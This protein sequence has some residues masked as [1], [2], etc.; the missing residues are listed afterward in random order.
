MTSGLTRRARE[1]LRQCRKV[2]VRLRRLTPEEITEWTRP[3]PKPPRPLL[4]P[5]IQKSIANLPPDCTI[6]LAPVD[7]LQSWM[8]PNPKVQPSLVVSRPEVKISVVGRV[9]QPGVGRLAPRSPPGL[10]PLITNAWSMQTLQSVRPKMNNQLLLPDLIPVQR[11]PNSRPSQP[12]VI[13]MPSTSSPKPAA[14]YS[15]PAAVSRGVVIDLCSSDEDDPP[16]KPKEFKSPGLD[17]PLFL[18]P[19][20]SITQIKREPIE[21]RC[22]VPP[23]PVQVKAEQR[24]GTKNNA[25]CVSTACTIR[26]SPPA[27]KF[28]GQQRRASHQPEMIRNKTG[29]PALSMDSSLPVV[30]PIKLGTL[31]PE[32]REQMKQ[33]LLKIQQK[34]GMTS[35]SNTG[36]KTSSPP[37]ATGT[38]KPSRNSV[39][40]RTSPLSSIQLSPNKSPNRPNPKDERHKE[41]KGKGTVTEKEPLPVPDQRKTRRKRTSAEPGSCDTDGEDDSFSAA[42]NRKAPRLDNKLQ[43][44]DQDEEMAEENGDYSTV[45]EV[46]LGGLD[47]EAQDG[48]RGSS[49]GSLT[50]ESR[51]GKK[52]TELTRLLEDECKE[53]RR[54][55]LEELPFDTHSNQRITR[56]R[57]KSLP[58]TVNKLV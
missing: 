16:P 18:P 28:M 33:S 4:Q 29:L 10:L 14:P 11:T 2:S 50:P 32:K 9:Q 36:E 45:I 51:N 37:S 53:L 7:S 25:Q 38:G 35:P 1:L 42:P 5:W 55:G 48:S 21:E 34:E 54:K 40:P 46:D 58:V 6:S 52:R 13:R 47:G 26:A 20:I 30:R 22:Y 19:G 44:Q 57:T 56:C 31:S 24:N 17:K 49:F 15:R 23:V 39:S 27:L 41:L 8:R 12:V 43:Y 3:K